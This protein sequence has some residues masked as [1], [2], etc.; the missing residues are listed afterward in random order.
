MLGS[1]ISGIATPTESAAVG[2]VGAILLT[3][4]KLISEEFTSTRKSDTADE[5]K[6][7][8]WLGIFAAYLA[9]AFLTGGMGVLLLTLALL[10]S[11]LVITLSRTALRQKFSE[12]LTEVCQSSLVI[13]SMVFVIFLGASVF[14][15][16]F[17]RLGGE[18]LATEYLASMPGGVNSAM[19]TVMA[20]MFV[21][22]FFLDPFE[23][24]F[25]VVP[26]V[27]PVLFAMNVDPVWFAVLI[28]INLQT[29]YLTPPFGFSLFFLRGVAPDGV[30]TIDI[31]RGILPF[32]I[33][34]LLCIAVV[35][36][37][38]ALTTYLPKLIYG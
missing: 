27:S 20:V 19:L 8:F 6:F 37:L 26:I 4:A 14:S 17:T 16:V 9:L 3:F 7:Y 23:I 36:Q 38:P 28:G 13:T 32:V 15:V 33:I 11:G 35:W 21:L 5:F 2:A 24:I 12:I 29:S 34:Q 1:I 30:T 22:G 31:Y 25:V 18:A 10:L